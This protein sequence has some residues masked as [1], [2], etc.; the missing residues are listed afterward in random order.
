[1]KKW[2]KIFIILVVIGII[3]TVAGYVF[4]YN[5]PHPKYENLKADYKLQASD[6]YNEFKSDAKSSSGK[7]NGKMLEIEGNLT[8][9]EESDSTLIAYFV[10]E[11]G[12]FGNQGVR[13]SLMPDF[14]KNLTQES[15]GKALKI[16]G[17]CTGFNETDVILEHGS[18]VK[19][20]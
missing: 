17:L 5:K 19:S 9:I 16:K 10:L 15:K 11:E 4:I 12:M 3:G 1:M 7:Y 2:I 8:E 13:I 18:I 14:V 20:E 6:L